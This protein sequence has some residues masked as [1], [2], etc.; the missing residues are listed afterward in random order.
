MKTAFF[1]CLNCSHTVQVEIDRGRIEEPGRCP[2]DVCQGVGT[3]SLVHNRSEF[4]DR[5]IIR[6]QETPDAVPDGQTP[7]TVS[8]C[9]YDELVDVAKP[10]D[11]LAVTGIF[12]SVPVRVNPRQRTIRSLFKT[13][14]DVVHVKRG[15]TQR[16]GY[17]K[18]TRTGSVRVPGVG[19]EGMDDEEE[20]GLGVV[21]SEGEGEGEET[22]AARSKSEEMEKKLLELS[23]RPDIYDLLAR[24]LA[25]SIWEMDDVKK[26]ILL[27][28]FGG[29]NKNITRGGGGGGP[30][31]RGDINV[32]LVGDPGTSKSQIL[33]VCLF[34][35]EF[36]LPLIIYL[37]CA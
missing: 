18:S 9:V 28:L 30:R 5:Q 27:Q 15:S 13:Y 33:Q 31:Y 4:A 36:V 14:I 25:P 11:R 22:P 37:V 26:G 6:L 23:Q 21:A 34:R 12:R 16:M 8:L 32:L 24:S 17:D 7:H 3:M 10:G 1:R 19:G 20:A 2:R 35:Q 29:T